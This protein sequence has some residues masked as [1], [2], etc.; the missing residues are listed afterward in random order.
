[1]KNNLLSIKNTGLNEGDGGYSARSIGFAKN[2]NKGEEST[3]ARAR[4]NARTRGR[5]E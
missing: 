5:T 4:A 2:A 3:R 1:M